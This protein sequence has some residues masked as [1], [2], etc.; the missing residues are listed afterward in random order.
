ML[1]DA[2]IET[3]NIEASAVRLTDTILGSNE[4]DLTETL[5]EIASE[6]GVSHIAYLRFSPDKSS[7]TS[8]LTATVT[9]S[10]DWT[11]RYF[12]KQYVHTDPVVTHGRQR[13]SSVR[14]GD[15]GGRQSRGPCVLR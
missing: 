15:F 2:T 9:Y 4:Q 3:I 8:L 5:K 7:D 10:R 13:R 6:I 1:S 14:L 11:Q 12:V